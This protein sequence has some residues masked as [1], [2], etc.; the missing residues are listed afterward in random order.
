M[1]PLWLAI[2]IIFIFYFSSGY[3]VWKLINIFY[4][5]DYATITHLIPLYHDWST[6][7]NNRTL[8]HQNWDLIE[9]PVITFKIQMHI[10]IILKCFEKY[11]CSSIAFFSRAP[12]VSNEQSCLKAIGLHDDLLLLSSFFTG[13]G[14]G[15][16]LQYSCLENPMDGGA[17]WAAVYGVAQSRTG[18]KRL[19]SSSLFHFFYFIISAPISF[20]LCS[21]MS[22]T[23]FFFFPLMFF[24]KPL[25]SVVVKLLYTC[26]KI[27]ISSVQSL[28]RVRLFATPQIAACQASLSIINS[29]SSLKLMSIE[30][31]CHPAISSSV[32]PFS[33]C[34]QSLPASG[35]FPMSQ[36]F[37]WSG[38]SIGVSASA[39]VPGLI[40]FRM[41]WLDMYNIYLF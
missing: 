5:C 37:T 13:E 11:K 29:Q 23:L 30:L 21:P 27:Y 33:S 1:F 25:S 10:R 20:S 39:S 38:Q 15:T 24:I 9:K 36:L 17:W 41:D 12:D 22:P 26:I 32:V 8:Y 3:R 18:L 35:S 19:S 2:V 28:S 34:P 6:E 40:S 4:Y 14:N 7:K 31:W 16:P